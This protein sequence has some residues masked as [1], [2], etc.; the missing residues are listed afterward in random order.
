MDG[1]GWVGAGGGWGGDRRGG[2]EGDWLI[3]ESLQN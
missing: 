3:E 2:R 1:G